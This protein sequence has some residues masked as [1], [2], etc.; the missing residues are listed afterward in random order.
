MVDDAA[1]AEVVRGGAGEAGDQ[2]PAGPSA[3]EVVERKQLAGQVVRGASVADPVTTS[4][5]F[6]VTDDSAAVVVS[7][8]KSSVVLYAQV[9]GGP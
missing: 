6:S 4:P 2:V 9:A 8:S 7:G 5:M 1:G 3:A